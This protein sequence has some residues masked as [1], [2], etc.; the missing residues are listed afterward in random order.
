MVPFIQ[1]F[2]HG[3]VPEDLVPKLKV[4]EKVLGR[5]ARVAIGFSGGVDSTFLAFSSAAVLGTE[6]VLLVTSVSETYPEFERV[7][8]EELCRGLGLRQV[9][10]QT[11]E[12]DIPGYRHNPPDRCYFCKKTLFDEVRRVAVKH[13]CDAVFEGGNSDD[14]CDFRPGRRALAELQILSPL[15]EAGLSK[16]EIRRL[17]HLA[18]LPTATKASFACLAS[19][20][21]YG[22]EI[23][24]E[25]LKRVESAE[26]GMREL[27]FEQFR[28][29]SHGDL[30]RVEVVPERMTDAWN[31]SREIDRICR[32][33]G[34]TYVCLDLKGYRTG[35]MNEIL[36]S[37][38]KD[39]L[40]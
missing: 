37:D 14:L 20:F 39:R 21:P 31:Q 36:A 19:R 6:N 15:V 18:G 22:E 26:T 23:T 16:D 3:T 1:K 28:V 35:A 24:A 17:S 9:V 27:G 34:F 29:R 32:S 30:A 7:E 2:S 13:G 8:A 40:Q 33:A 5:H 4:L 12:I 25:K 11:Q 38:E 10:I